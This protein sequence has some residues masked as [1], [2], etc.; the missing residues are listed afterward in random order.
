MPRNKRTTSQGRVKMALP[1][2]STSWDIGFWGKTYDIC[3]PCSIFE[4]PKSYDMQNIYA[5]LRGNFKVM[6]M[7]RYI[8]FSS[9]VFYGYFAGKIRP[10]PQKN[11]PNRFDAGKR[12]KSQIF[13]CLD[14][15][16]MP[17]CDLGK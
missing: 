5:I 16:N 10:L 11:N 6:T 12:G 14:Q 2:F 15:V 7:A 3:Y 4:N 1:F 9:F 13:L 17:P 8:H